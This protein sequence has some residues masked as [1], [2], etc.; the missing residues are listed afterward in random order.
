MSRG[1]LRFT[2]N[3]NLAA[4]DATNEPDGQITQNLS[5]PFAKNI[6]VFPK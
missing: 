5:S 3:D 4:M 1:T 2:G 6:S